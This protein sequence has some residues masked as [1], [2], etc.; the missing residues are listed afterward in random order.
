[1]DGNGDVFTTQSLHRALDAT[2]RNL[3][4]P[5]I[6]GGEQKDDVDDRVVALTKETHDARVA[7]RIVTV[8]ML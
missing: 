1:M 5:G 7:L 2:N 6:A 3:S 4:S 8:R